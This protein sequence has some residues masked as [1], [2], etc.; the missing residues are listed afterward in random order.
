MKLL[1]LVFAIVGLGTSALVTN[2]QTIAPINQTGGSGTI[3][4]VQQGSGTITPG[5]GS[6][7]I[8]P[9]GKGA[10]PTAKTFLPASQECKALDLKNGDVRFFREANQTPYSQIVSIQSSF[11]GVANSDFSDGTK[12]YF[13]IEMNRDYGLTGKTNPNASETRMRNLVTH[14]LGALIADTSVQH[15]FQAQPGIIQPT[16]Y[17]LF[18]FNVN[19]KWSKYYEGKA[20]ICVM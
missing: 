1:P 8:T 4:P 14:G 9:A 7:T 16:R 17:I 19:G 13:D 18:R 11:K 15:F 10:K 12:R 5:S 2:A 20:Q 6:G 3:T